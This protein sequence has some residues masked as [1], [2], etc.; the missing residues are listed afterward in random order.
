MS[1]MERNQGSPAR[2]HMSPPSSPSLLTIEVPHT[3]T[4]LRGLRLAETR[5]TPASSRRRHRGSVCGA[6]RSRRRAALHTLTSLD[7][8]RRRSK[9]GPSSVI[10]MGIATAFFL[11]QALIPYYLKPVHLETQTIKHCSWDWG[12]ISFSP[13]VDLRRRRMTMRNI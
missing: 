13:P 6:L 9:C 8:A 11:N 2:Q 5:L 12:C 7:G 1:F 4:A 3:C 10:A